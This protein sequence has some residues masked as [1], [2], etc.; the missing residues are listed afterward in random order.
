MH[1]LVV[2]VVISAAILL[3]PFAASA[4]ESCEAAPSNAPALSKAA[5]EAKL[6]SEGY[7]KIRELRAHNGCYEAK[8]FDGN[9][10]R[11]ELE[12][13]AHTGKVTKAE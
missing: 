12:I 1:K 9:G 11:F 10:K 3:A 6:H 5:I 2:S 8:G 4:E 13:D 7:T